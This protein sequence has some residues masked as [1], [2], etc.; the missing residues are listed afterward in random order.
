M[1]LRFEQ[2]KSVTDNI[3]R[4]LEKE[5][6]LAE[7][8]SLNTS[9]LAAFVAAAAAKDVRKA[10]FFTEDSPLEMYL[11]PMKSMDSVLEQVLDENKALA[12]AK[13]ATDESA[14]IA[15]FCA[16]VT[17]EFKET[18][19]LKA[20]P[21]LFADKD[22]R[23]TRGGRVAF[24][25]SRVLSSAFEEFKKK[26]ALL[27]A[28]YV[29]SF[30]DACEDVYAGSCE[31]CILPI[32]NSRDGAL[33]TVYNLIE[34]YELC[35]SRVCSVKSDEITT[36]FALLCS[37]FHGIIE[38]HGRQSVVLRMPIR[39]SLTWSRIFTGATVLGI[40]LVKTVAVPLGYTD[41][42]AHI[43]TF[44]SDGEGMFAFLLF[45]STIRAEYTLMGA[46]EVQT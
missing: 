10:G 37:G 39:E 43:C 24:S 27:T 12:S 32:E 35:I 46:Y 20:T 41:G 7:R 21:A 31:W 23:A 34:R 13:T 1:R 2:I 9:E 15:D 5:C 18:A 25:E 8:M 42:Y 29:Q 6:S 14:F 40:E 3:T 19:R 33:L 11:P 4:Y 16:K 22:E 38:M 26:D 17:A 36:K 44:A 30:S 28:T 45:L